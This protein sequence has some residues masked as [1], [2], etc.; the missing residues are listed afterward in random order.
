VPIFIDRGAPL[1]ARAHTIASEHRFSIPLAKATPG[2]IDGLSHP[3]PLRENCSAALKL[4]VMKF[5]AALQKIGFDTGWRRKSEI[6]AR[7]HRRAPAV[8]FQLLSL[9]PLRPR[10]DLFR[11]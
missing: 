11:R 5:P 9:S 8:F 1:H 4:Y 6:A 7:D 10:I 2:S 3:R